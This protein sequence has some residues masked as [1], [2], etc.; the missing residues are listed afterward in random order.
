MIVSKHQPLDWAELQ[1]L[2][3]LT[4]DVKDSNTQAMMECWTASVKFINE[5]ESANGRVLVMLF[6]RSRS[7]SIVLAYLVMAK[8]QSLEKAWEVIHSKC[9]HLIDRTL[10]YEGQLREWEGGEFSL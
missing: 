2:S 8:N 6:G 4:C 1:D 3:V 9:W 10:A 7:A 5:V